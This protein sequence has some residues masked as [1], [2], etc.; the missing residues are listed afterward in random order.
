[1]STSDLDG[2]LVGF[3]TTVAEKGLVGSR[4]GAQPVG[5]GGLLGNEIQVGYVMNLLHLIFN[6]LGEEF[7]VMSQ[8]ASGNAT[9]AIQIVLSV[10]RL[11]ETSLSRINSQLVAAVKETSE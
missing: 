1:M 4:I 9:D 11:Q 3:G 10:G 6:G 7:V 5:Q 8:G 2:R